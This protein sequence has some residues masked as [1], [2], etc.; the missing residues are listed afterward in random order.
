MALCSATRR[1]GQRCTAQALPGGQHCF[2]HSPEL[3]ERR[4]AASASG[5]RN[6]ATSVRVARRMPA[7]LRDV[8]DTLMTVLAELHDGSLEPRVGSAMGSVAG[9][10]IKLYEVSDFEA[11]LSALEANN[12]VKQHR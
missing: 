8:L 1:D 10:I 3:A 9:T 4:K 6:K 7:N 5:G 11:R 12:H 2:A